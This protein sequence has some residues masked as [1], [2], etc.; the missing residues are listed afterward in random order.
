M[1]GGGG[2]VESAGFWEF[3]LAAAPEGQFSG[4]LSVN[5]SVFWVQLQGTPTCRMSRHLDQELWNGR[6]ELDDRIGISGQKCWHQLVMPVLGAED[7]GW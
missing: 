3:T 4:L 5:R 2:G 7:G 6:K 1:G